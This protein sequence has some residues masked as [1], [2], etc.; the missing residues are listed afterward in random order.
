MK[1]TLTEVALAES[2]TFKWGGK[3]NASITKNWTS[4]SDCSLPFE[5]HTRKDSWS[6]RCRTVFKAVEA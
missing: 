1:R 5:Y 6:S 4:A 2:K 3:P